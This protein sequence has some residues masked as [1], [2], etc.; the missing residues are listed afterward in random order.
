M[1][2]LFINNRTL[3]FMPVCNFAILAVS[4]YICRGEVASTSAC[5]ALKPDIEDFPDLDLRHDI[6]SCRDHK[7][8]DHVEDDTFRRR[9]VTPT[10]D[11]ASPVEMIRTDCMT[12]E[13]ASEMIAP[14]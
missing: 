10:R 9:S 12:A 11:I 5:Q 2:L 6:D 8:H 7:Q 14:Y 1:L 4:E 3:I 13:N